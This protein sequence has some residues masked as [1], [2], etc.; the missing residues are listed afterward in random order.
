MVLPQRFLAALLVGF[1]ALA[2]CA[3]ESEEG[4]AAADSA[5]TLQ[6]QVI[7]PIASGDTKSGSYNGAPANRA[8]SFTASGGDKITAE[9]S[10]GGDEVVFITDPSFLVLQDS[11]N[12]RINFTVPA[13]PSR[14]LRLAFRD[15]NN[16]SPNYTVKLTIVA[17]ACNPAAEP[18]HTYLGT[19]DECEALHWTC[20]G[21]ESRFINA[22][23]CGCERPN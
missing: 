10:T 5:L 22:C 23:G 9:V 3:S 11:S 14:P 7:G 12:G 17:G 4:V 13:G 8:F 16:A 1:A 18:W 2:G 21:G 20:P 19:P 15:R 6:A